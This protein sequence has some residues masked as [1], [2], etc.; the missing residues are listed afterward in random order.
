MRGFWSLF[1]EGVK[2]AERE[3]Q[4][5]RRIEG[6][7]EAAKGCEDRLRTNFAQ[8]VERSFRSI[9]RATLQGF[10]GFQGASACPSDSFLRSAH[11]AGAKS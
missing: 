1:K 2:G 9:K 10:L 5:Q 11:S 8:E 4:V 3:E 7:V 6:L